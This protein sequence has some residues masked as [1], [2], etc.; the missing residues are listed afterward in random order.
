MNYLYTV[1]VYSPITSI[2][3]DLCMFDF[4]LSTTIMFTFTKMSILF[5]KYKADF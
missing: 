3:N 1:V 5:Q 2:M 4:T